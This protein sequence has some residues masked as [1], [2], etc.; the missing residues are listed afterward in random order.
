MK[1]TY[2]EN[3]LNAAAKFIFENNTDAKR[4]WKDKWKIE[5]IKESMKE[6][7]KTIAYGDSDIGETMGFI[8]VVEHV[9]FSEV[10]VDFFVNPLL[11]DHDVNIQQLV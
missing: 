5:N 3:Q 6:F 7:A 8:V 4:L 10:Y 2:D 9:A 11:K 1:I